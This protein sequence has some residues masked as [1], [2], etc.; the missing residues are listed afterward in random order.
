ME[1]NKA[2]SI[3]KKY[4]EGQS[5][6]SEEQF[7]FDSTENL[8]S[9]MKVWSTFVKNNKTATPKDFNERLWESF[10][11]KKNRKRKLLIG[12]LSV[13]ASVSVLIALF[14]THPAPEE[15]NYSE[16][17]ALLNIARDMVNHTDLAEIEERIIYENDIVIIYTTKEK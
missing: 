3:I 6:L 17:E 2:D 4:K 12:A 9:S 15:L 13:A 11:N 7:L 5:T 16:K 14:F 10:Q 8:K 1:E